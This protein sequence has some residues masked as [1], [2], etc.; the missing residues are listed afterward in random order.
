[1]GDLAMCILMHALTVSPEFL[2][3]LQH[4][5][6]PAASSQSPTKPKINEPRPK[7]PRPDPA[8]QKGGSKGTFMRVPSELLSL[9]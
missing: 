5:L 4:R 2:N 1:M 3:L 6:A 8:H 9:G 7:K